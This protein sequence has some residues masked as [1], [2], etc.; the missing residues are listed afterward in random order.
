MATMLVTIL[1]KGKNTAKVSGMEAESN[2]RTC[3]V[4]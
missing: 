2:I 1:Q 4:V 3:D